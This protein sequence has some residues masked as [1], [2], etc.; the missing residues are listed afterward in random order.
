MSFILNIET[1]TQV[2]SVSLAK[3]GDL[4]GCKETSEPNVHSSKLTLLIEELMN[5]NNLHFS[6]LNAVAVSKGPGSY[7]WLKVLSP[8]Q[9][10]HLDA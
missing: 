1:A 6:Q 10:V 2:C 9:N 8:L 3:E 7:Y 5:V 4:L